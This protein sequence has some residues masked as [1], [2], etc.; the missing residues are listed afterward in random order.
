MLEM[1]DAM[2]EV[3][4][5][6][7]DF[8]VYFVTIDPERDDRETL[9][10]YVGSFDPRIVGLVPKDETELAAVA[11]EYRVYYKK[12]PSQNGYTMDHFAG[13][14]LFD[15]AGQFAGVIDPQESPDVRKT[16]LQRLLSG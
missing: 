4:T 2:K 9:R 3:G 15:K 7:K 6:A 1:A 10:R 8:R 16:K 12:V 14:L 5:L 11:K 13:V